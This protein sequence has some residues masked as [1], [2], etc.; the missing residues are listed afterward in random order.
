MKKTAVDYLFEKLWGI[1]KDKFT[2]QMI[3]K[4]AKKKEKSQITDA[5][6]QGI[7]E[8]FDY[9]YHNDNPKEESGEE[10]YNKTYEI[11]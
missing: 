11:K 7:C 10:Y 8:G 9:G 6:D 4:E 1:P 5:Y 3:L 2:W